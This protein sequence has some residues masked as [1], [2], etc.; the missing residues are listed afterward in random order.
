MPVSRS[1]V[2][3]M[4]WWTMPTPNG[5]GIRSRQAESSSGDWLVDE[6]QRADA[7]L[8]RIQ[9]EVERLRRAVNR[10]D[11]SVR[12]AQDAVSRYKAENAGLRAV[13]QDFIDDH[14]CCRG[15][16]AQMME[17]K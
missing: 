10:K 17:E 12:E 14:P 3:E 2:S 7:A 16:V 9:A 6:A 13:F 4:R 11:Q 5:R 8:D 15:T 1:T